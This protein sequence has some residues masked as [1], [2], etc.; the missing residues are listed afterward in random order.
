[1]YGSYT[2]T[3]AALMVG[4]APKRAARLRSSPS[5]GPALFRPRSP[6]ILP[7]D[8]SGLMVPESNRMAEG[9]YSI[10]K[11]SLLNA[12]DHSGSLSPKLHM[13]SGAHSAWLYR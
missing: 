5:I 10:N 2:T 12:L 8:S 1:M 11:E 3:V 13:T 4:S 9:W 6:W 7:E